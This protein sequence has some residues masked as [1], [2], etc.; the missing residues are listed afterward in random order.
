[1]HEN[2]MIVSR[3]YLLVVEIVI[4]DKLFKFVFIVIILNLLCCYSVLLPVQQLNFLSTLFKK[5]HPF[6]EI[7]YCV[8]HR[9]DFY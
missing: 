1:M 5:M 7:E 3:V 4:L 2:K 6:F 8:C 9:C